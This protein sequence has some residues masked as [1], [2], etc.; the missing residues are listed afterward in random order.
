MPSWTGDLC[1]KNFPTKFELLGGENWSKFWVLFFLALLIF[2]GYF[3]FF[4][5][6]IPKFSN[7]INIQSYITNWP[8]YVHRVSVISATLPNQD[9]IAS[10]THNSYFINNSRWAIPEVLTHTHL[11][12]RTVVCGNICKQSSHVIVTRLALH[13]YSTG[14]MPELTY[15]P[16]TMPGIIASKPKELAMAH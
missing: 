8:T 10:I 4:F 1:T 15:Y 12:Y 14:I 5:L 11:H 2:Q 7:N 3:Q 13:K 6:P 16:K 9:L